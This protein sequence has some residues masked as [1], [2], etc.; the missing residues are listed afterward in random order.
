MKA[1]SVPFDI[2]RLDQQNIDATYLFGRS[3]EIR[4][5]AVV[6]LADLSSYG[7][8]DLASLGEAVRA[9]TGLIVVNSQVVDPALSTLLG[10]KFKQHYTSTDIFHRTHDH[11]IV[12][13]I[14]E[15]KNDQLS[16]N[17][18]FSVRSWVQPTSAE[19]LLDQ[20]Q[21]PVLTVNQIG[22]GVSAIWLELQPSR[23]YAVRLFGGLSSSVHWFGAWA[24]QSRPMWTIPI[25]SFSNLTTGALPTRV[26]SPIGAILSRMRRLFNRISLSH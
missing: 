20:G 4:Y 26:F 14:A 24:M 18:D 23:H 1:W 10:L 13:G 6:W 16:Q 15:S 11:Y 9:G 17:R 3:G 22:P 8:Q 7:D 12:R 21:H 25:W 5:G 19:V 2:L